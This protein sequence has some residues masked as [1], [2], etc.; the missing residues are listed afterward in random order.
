MVEPIPDGGSVILPVEIVRAWLAEEGAADGSGD[1]T[2]EQL[3]SYFPNRSVSGLRKWCAAG[4]FPHAYK[5]GEKTWMIPRCCVEEFRN[6]WS[7]APEVPRLAPR[8]RAGSLREAAR[9]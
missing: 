8:R 5:M 1:M 3:Q 9:G 2:L 7:K 4:R 6:N